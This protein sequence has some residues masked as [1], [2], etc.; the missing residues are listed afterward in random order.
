MTAII[1]YHC[2]VRGKIVI[3][4]D[5]RVTWGNAYV[6][7]PE[8]A[9]K[10]L[11][12][13]GWAVGLAG[14]CRMDHVLR[15][16]FDKITAELETGDV[17]GFADLYKG[18]I[19]N[20]D[21]T[22]DDDP[23][24]KGYGHESLIGTGGYLYYLATDFTATLVPAGRLFCAGGGGD[25]A[26]GAAAALLADHPRARLEAVMVRAIEIAITHNR[27]CGPPVQVAVVPGSRE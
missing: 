18:A 1:G 24:P 25:L 8:A 23:G 16:V 6:D 13:P 7:D 17:Y 26:L 20:D 3:A 15:G 9:L 27:G 10:L 5:S 19:V 2:P 11:Q 4:A 22:P 12:G 21:Y 14:P